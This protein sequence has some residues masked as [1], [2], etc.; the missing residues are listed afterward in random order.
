LKHHFNEDQPFQLS[1]IIRPAVFTSQNKKLDVL[2]R[3]FR[4]NRNHLAIVLDEYGNVSGLV[5]IEDVL[6]QIVGEIEDEYDIGEEDGYIKPLDDGACIVK[7]ATAIKDFN[8]YFH[9]RFNAQN[10]DTIGNLIIK[11]FDYVP[12]R[13]EITKLKDLRFKILHSDNRR[14]YLMEV[15]AIKKHSK[16]KKKI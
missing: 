12:Q 4:I 3:E 1:H 16:F 14:I 15:K 5:T 8:H 7:G 6:E 9:T 2:L 11:Y 10:Y 13:G